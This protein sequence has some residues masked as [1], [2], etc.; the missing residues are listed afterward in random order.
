MDWLRETLVQKDL[1]KIDAHLIQ[2]QQYGALW[3]FPVYEKRVY[4]QFNN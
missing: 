3:C 1:R 2:R 4:A